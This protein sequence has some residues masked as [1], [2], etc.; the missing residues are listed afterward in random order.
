MLSLFKRAGRTG[1]QL[2]VFVT[3]DGVALRAGIAGPTDS[4]PGNVISITRAAEPLWR[5]SQSV[6]LLST[7]LIARSD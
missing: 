6:S 2:G 3:A 4:L 1:S 7:T 5:Q